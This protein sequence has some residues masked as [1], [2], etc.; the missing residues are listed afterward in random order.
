MLKGV[1]EESRFRA[2]VSEP[3]TRCSKREKGRIKTLVRRMAEFLT[4]PPFETS[5]YIPSLVTA[6]EIRSQMWEEDV[7]LLDRIRVVQADYLLVV[8]DE[9]SFGIGG[10]VELAS[11]LGKPVVFMSRADRLSRFMLGVSGNAVKA[12]VGVPYLRY[13]E[14]RDLKPQLIEVLP[15]ILESVAMVETNELPLWDFGH[16]L[17]RWREQRGLSVETLARRSGLASAQIRA[18]EMSMEEIRRRLSVYED[19]MGTLGLSQI[20]LTPRQREQLLNPGLDALHRLAD[21]LNVPLAQLVGE[22]ERIMMRKGPARVSQG[23]KAQV[24]ENRLDSLSLKAEQFDLT[25]REFL[26]LK[27]R[28]VDEFAENAP[29]GFWQSH[30]KVYTISDE[31]V[32]ACLASLRQRR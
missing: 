6:P 17:K 24:K 7:Y 16:H 10:E 29:D 30:R 28:L 19:E 13:R 25:Y 26:A 9:T 18:F 8:A 3:I 14:W 15:P 12:H 11:A 2:Y 23:L 22:P 21:A 5:L 1:Y 20:Q 4:Q 31:E 32:A 27:S